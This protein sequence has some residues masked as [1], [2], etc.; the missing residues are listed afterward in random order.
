MCACNAAQGLAD[1]RMARVE[2]LLGDAMRA[3]NRSHPAQQRR[4]RV[5][6]AGS[7]EIGTDGLRLG[8]SKVGIHALCTRRRYF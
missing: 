1:H 7:G 8:R 5:A 2:R 4:Q 3:Y 6:E